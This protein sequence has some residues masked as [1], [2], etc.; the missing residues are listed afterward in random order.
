MTNLTDEEREAVEEYLYNAD[1]GF[2]V[3]NLMEL[4]PKDLLKELGV[5]L[6]SEQ[7]DEEDETED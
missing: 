6:V 4:M 2:L 3:E 7:E 5:S 1:I